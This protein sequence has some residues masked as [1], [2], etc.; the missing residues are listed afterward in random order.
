[1]SFGPIQLLQRGLL[2]MIIPLMMIDKS[3]SFS[4]KN[5]STLCCRE[6]VSKPLSEPI[7]S[8]NLVTN[9]M[10][11]MDLRNFHLLLRSFQ[12][13]ITVQVITRLQSSSLREKRWT[14]EHLQ[15]EKTNRLF[16][17]IDKMHFPFSRHIY[18]VMSLIAFTTSSEPHMAL[19]QRLYQMLLH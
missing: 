1:M 15:L 3:L 13:Q 19:I 17:M 8:S 7:K 6:R 16:Y 9:S 18:R 11:G 12:P 14:S 5:Q 10:H 4:V 2:S